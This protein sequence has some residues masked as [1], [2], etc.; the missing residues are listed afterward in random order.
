MKRKAERNEKKTPQPIH[1]GT[2]LFPPSHFLSL[3]SFDDKESK[4]NRE[5]LH[6]TSGLEED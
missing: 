3:F 6:D 5:K 1:Q 4:R 2:E